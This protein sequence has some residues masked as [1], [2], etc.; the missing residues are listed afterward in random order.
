M[1]RRPGD[2]KHYKGVLAPST[3][4]EDGAHDELIAVTPEGRLWYALIAGAANAVL[5][6]LAITVTGVAIG[7]AGF[8]SGGGWELI[9]V[10][11]L[12]GWLGGLTGVLAITRNVFL[13]QR[14][15]IGAA[16]AVC[17]V[18]TI[19]TFAV[20]WGIAGRVGQLGLP[21]F[22]ALVGAVS[23]AATWAVTR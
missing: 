18:A 22:V 5:G 9:A 1:N 20:A 17:A 11:G 15:P 21:G 13:G 4:A 2:S 10:V 14:L 7:F 8:G 3:P 6:V 16:V 12:A 19:V 23:A